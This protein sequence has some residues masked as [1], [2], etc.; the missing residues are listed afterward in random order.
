M[1]EEIAR[2]IQN[3]KVNRQKSV[4]IHFQVLKNAEALRH[5]DA[6]EFCR[7]VGIEATWAVEFKKMLALADLMRA[8]GFAL[9]PESR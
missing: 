9:S 1:I 8:E 7:M 3:A 4:T 2:E 5:M 6:K